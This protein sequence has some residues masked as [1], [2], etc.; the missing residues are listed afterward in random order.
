M[1]STWQA[2]RDIVF[3]TLYK[4]GYKIGQLFVQAGKSLFLQAIESGIRT[5]VREFMNSDEVMTVMENVLQEEMDLAVQQ[6]ATELGLDS[7][8]TN[9][10]PVEEVDGAVN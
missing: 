4:M 7:T 9:E 10:P 1:Q 2:L 5:K 3:R 6:I 8:N